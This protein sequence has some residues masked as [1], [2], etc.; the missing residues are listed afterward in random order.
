MG[1][2]DRIKSEFRPSILKPGIYQTKNLDNLLDTYVL[3]SDGI[4]TRNGF[5]YDFSGILNVIREDSAGSYYRFDFLDGQILAIHSEDYEGTI[6]ETLWK[7]KNKKR[8][9]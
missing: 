4:L 3:T 6:L 1:M 5:L 2:F 9:R 8:K 7:R